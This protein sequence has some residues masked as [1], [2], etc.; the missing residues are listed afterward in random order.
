MQNNGEVVIQKTRQLIQDAKNRIEHRKP[1]VKQSK[2]LI[3]SEETCPEIPSTNSPSLKRRVS[4]G[5]EPEQRGTHMASGLL[6]KD[7]SIAPFAQFDE[8]SASWIP[9]A[10]IS[11]ETNGD[12]RS[13]TLSGPPDRYKNWQDAKACILEMAK[14]WIDSQS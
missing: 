6:Y 3:R 11:W 10:D 5:R 2:K 9:M 7:R 12:R 1:V 14:E 13:Y 8:N 4:E